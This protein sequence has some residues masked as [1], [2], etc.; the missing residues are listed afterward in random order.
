MGIGEA[1][2]TILS[3]SGVPTPV[4]HTRMVGAGSRMAPADDVDGAAKASPLWAKYGTR[5]EAESAREKLAARVDKAAAGRAT[6]GAAQGGA[7]GGRQGR[8]RRGG[9]RR[10]LPEVPP[11][12]GDPEASRAGN[13]RHAQEE[14]LMSSTSASRLVPPFTEEHEALRE[15]LRTFVEKE[16]RPHAPAWEEA[17]EFPR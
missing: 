2:V 12:Q 6:E 11:G 9:R 13:I 3:E 7:Q 8:R 15:S 16:I 14:I 17:R 5:A 10:R 4:V 1:A